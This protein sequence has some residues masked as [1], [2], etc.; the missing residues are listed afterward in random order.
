[1]AMH[2]VVP[3]LLAALLAGAPLLG[4][5]RELVGSL[6]NLKGPV[7]LL[8]D[9]VERTISR[10]ERLYEG[11]VLRTGPGGSLGLLLRDDTSISLG[12]ESRVALEH[13]RFAPAQ[14]ELGLV[15]RLFRGTMAFV[16]GIVARLAPDSVKVEAPVATVGVR[17]TTFL[18]K[19]EGE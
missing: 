17:G 5:E 7:F 11:D 12:P 19:A 15:V 8:R 13:F 10:P 18:V 1:M 4:A 3:V 9:G 14:R 16:S 6:R 2:R